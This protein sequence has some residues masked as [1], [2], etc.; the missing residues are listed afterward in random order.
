MPRATV[1]INDT[2]RIDLKTLS[3]GYVVVRKFTYGQFLER[4]SITMNMQV[5]QQKG[6][7]AKGTMKMAARAVTFFEFSNC[8]VDHNLELDDGSPMDFKKEFTLDLLDPRIGQEIGEAI[9][10]I[11]TFD[12]EG[13]S[14]TGSAA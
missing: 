9:D 14:S 12:S 6:Q 8:I 7:N 11:N 2:E 13:N 10:R 3:E 5:E 4:Q 1:S